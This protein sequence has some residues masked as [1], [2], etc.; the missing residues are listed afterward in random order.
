MDNIGVGLNNLQM[1]VY[2]DVGFS[3]GSRMLSGTLTL[4]GNC[5]DH[6][7]SGMKGGNLFIH[8][9]SGNYLGGKPNS[10]NEGILDGLI[11][12]KGNV[13]QNSIQRM[14][15]GNVIIGHGISNDVA[16]KNMLLHSYE[17]A[18]S[19]LA[20]KIKKAFK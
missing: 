19:G 15:R 12:V 9:S 17:V 18:S 6:A 14:R 16:I 13:G 8:G 7:A 4:Y 11:Y 5:L 3:L 10:A 20:K 2:G 1:T